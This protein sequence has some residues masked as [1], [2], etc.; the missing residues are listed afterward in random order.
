MSLYSALRVLKAVGQTLS[1][2]LFRWDGGRGGLHLWDSY[3]TFCKDG[4]IHLMKLLDLKSAMAKS[5]MRAVNA[6]RPQGAKQPALLNLNSRFREGVPCKVNRRKR[7]L[8]LAVPVSRCEGG[9]TE[10]SN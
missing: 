1:D 4:N 7:V 6:S 9:A 10:K 5:I 8:Q 3:G 2:S